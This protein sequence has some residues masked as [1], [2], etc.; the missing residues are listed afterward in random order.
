MGPVIGFVFEGPNAVD[1]IR[2]LVGH[3]FSLVAEPG[4]IRGDY[5]LEQPVTSLVRTRTIYNMIH[6]S[7]TV[8]EAEEEIKLWFEDEEILEY[9]RVHEDLYKY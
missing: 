3:T 4:T 7:G 6:A 1:K 9:K 5:G 2:K 8:E